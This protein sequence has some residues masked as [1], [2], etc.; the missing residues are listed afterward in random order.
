[1]GEQIVEAIRTHFPS[2][3]KRVAL[4]QALDLLESTG[5]ANAK[6]RIH[7]YPHEF[8]GGMKQ[9]VMI[10]MALSCQPAL[11]IADEPTTALDVTVQAQILQLL[12]QVVRDRNLSVML[13][14]HDLGVVAGFTQ[15]TLVMY[16]GRLVE[17][18]STD[19][20]FYEP[21][22]PYSAGLVAS[23]PRLDLPKSR[24]LVAIPGRPP[25]LHA[26]PPGCCFSP[27][28][29]YNDHD[30]CVTAQPE[31]VAVE[32]EPQ[33]SA[34]CYYAGSLDLRSTAIS[35]S[36]I[37]DAGDL[38]QRSEPEV[39]ISVSH[40][41]KRF[42]IR[43]PFGGKSEVHVALDDVSLD[44]RRGETL[45][46][47]GESGS[48]KTTFGRCM[49][50]LVKANE[51]SVRFQGED[52][53]KASGRRLRRLRR[54][55]QMIF[56]DPYGSLD[57]R[58]RVEQLVAEPMKIHRLWGRPGYDSERVSE[59][60]EIVGLSP[61]HR[62]RYP[63]DFSG[64]ERQR[65]GIARA[66]AVHPRFLICDEPVSSLDVSIRAQIINLLMDLQA[67]FD[68]TFLFIA[69]DLALVRHLCDRVAVIEKGRLVEIAESSRLY[70]QPEHPY[71]RALLASA[72]LPD[73]R[74]ERQRRKER[75]S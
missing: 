56:Q 34:A 72:P 46:L 11:L 22:H 6:S 20:I 31:L 55:M 15:R 28:C 8:S 48:G 64:G 44:I 17:H 43:A 69:H 58:F 59:L 9:R 19:Q 67:K 73:P 30:R 50:K 36:S 18:G 26:P 24:R 49:L 16:G 32:T 38:R 3:P 23:V 74:L 71:T 5:I 35:V 2:T 39:L 62:H 37:G 63:A 65:I 4:A 12:D 33:H 25:N 53:L 75:V 70:E 21:A 60:L 57:P 1:V 41:S 47:V 61:Q 7:A 14:T 13:I 54:E 51:G 29:A 27:R 68:L 40:L 10:A 45:G 52:I 66:L 42:T